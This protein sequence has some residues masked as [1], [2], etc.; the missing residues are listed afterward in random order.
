MLRQLW[1]IEHGAPVAARVVLLA[2]AH[3]TH[4]PQLLGIVHHAAH[5]IR[6]VA[7]VGPCSV[8]LL[9]VFAALGH[10]LERETHEL[11]IGVTRLFAIF[12]RPAGNHVAHHA[13]QLAL[14]EK[15]ERVEGVVA[16]PIVLIHVDND[17]VPGLGHAS[18]H[19]V[20]VALPRLLVG[21]HLRPHVVRRPAAA[22]HRAHHLGL[23]LAHRDAER[24]EHGRRVNLHGARGRVGSVNV[25]R[26]RVGKLD[27]G[28]QLAQV[29]VPDGGV[30][31]DPCLD[32]AH[33]VFGG[34]LGHARDHVAHDVFRLNAATVVLA[35]ALVARAHERTHDARKVRRGL[36]D[37]Q[38]VAAH[39]GFLRLLDVIL[40]AAGKRQDERDANDADRAGER[41]QERAALLGH[42][43]VERERKRLAEAHR[44][45]ALASIGH[46][47]GLNLLGRDALARRVD[48]SGVARDQAVL[49]A[50]DAI[51]VF[52][53]KLRVVRD[54]DN[55]A[56]ATEL[57]Q[58]IHDLDRGLGIEGA[59]GLV[60]EDDL[61]V[62]NDGAGDGHALHLPARELVWP[63]AQVLAEAHAPKRLLRPAPP[64]RLGRAG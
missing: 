36:V 24:V 63:L 62:V 57:L 1:R 21:E 5:I 16:D 9:G 40:G 50:H 33:V 60:G 47:V 28:H 2:R 6:V 27:V 56:V 55:E 8:L 31:V 26:R 18:G 52:L 10:Q 37:G 25:E 22:V 19:H 54:H 64:L 58:D 34:A 59:G 45:L 49:D 4:H 29:A 32:G 30:A 61:G 41:R 20:V 13:A 14:V 12:H 46:R 35:G 38:R 48:R 23:G 43:V 17:L 44:A 39:R 15:P 3:D 53:G 11:V 42:E 51:G 7:H